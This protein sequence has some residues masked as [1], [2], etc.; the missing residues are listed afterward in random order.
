MLPLTIFYQNV[1]GLRTKTQD[2][3]LALSSSDYD[4]I[5]LTETWLGSD[6][7]NSELSSDYV[8]HRLDRNP[9]TS[10]MHRG[11][12]VL[13]GVKRHL[14]CKVISLTNAD[15]VEQ[16]AVC[17]S[18]PKQSVYICCVYI[19]PNSE[20]AIYSRHASCVQELCELAATTD[21]V[22]ALGDYNLPRLSWEFDTD[23]N[24][25]IPTNASSEQEIALT[26]SILACG[27][28][29]IQDVRNANERLLDLA[30]VSDSTRIEL[31]ESP[32]GI[33]K[34]DAHHKPFIIKFD[35]FRDSDDNDPDLLLLRL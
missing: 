12:G 22:I 26:Q 29:Q 27:L 24:S 5:A 28:Q 19:R 17:I 35:Y 9:S 3:R 21:T 16:V 18:L 32:C 15:S 30:F 31:F 34:I 33:L 20:P 7:L 11:G 14:R 6:I 4:V 10:L 8:I 1:R 23:V 2:L 13:I 25:Y